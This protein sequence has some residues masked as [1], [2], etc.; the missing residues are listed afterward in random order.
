MFN[1]VRYSPTRLVKSA[2][3]FLSSHRV[4]VQ[5]VKYSM[6]AEALENNFHA[7]PG[8]IEAAIQLHRDEIESATEASIGARRR[9]G[10]MGTAKARTISMAVVAIRWASG[11]R[12]GQASQAGF[13]R[14]TG[15]A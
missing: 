11:Q 6:S 1:E 12:C 3:A 10:A 5:P 15:I 9:L 13:R 4:D 14:E 2:L 7:V 8:T